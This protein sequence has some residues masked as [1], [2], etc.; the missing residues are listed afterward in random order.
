MFFIVRRQRKRQGAAERAKE[1]EIDDNME[2]TWVPAPKSN[3]EFMPPPQAMYNNQQPSMPPPSYNQS[4]PS[5]SDRKDRGRRASR[6]SDY[7]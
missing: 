2:L 7:A 3:G 6:D 4:S 1:R 5:R